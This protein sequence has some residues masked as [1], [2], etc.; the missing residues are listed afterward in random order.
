MEVSRRD[1]SRLIATQVA[2]VANG[3]RLAV[4]DAFPEVIQR[5]Y[6]VAAL[7]GHVSR[8]CAGRHGL[9]YRVPDHAPQGHRLPFL[10]APPMHWGCRSVLLPEVAGPPAPLE[11]FDQFLRRR[12]EAFQEL[13]L[14]PTRARMFRQGRLRTYSLLEATTGVPLTLE[15]LGV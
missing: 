5:V 2:A 4:Y 10:G 6:L 12:G 3:A 15:E 9:R 8:I 11:T 13:V 1:V 7:D 14:G